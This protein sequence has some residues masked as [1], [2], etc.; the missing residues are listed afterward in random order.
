M[1]EK[2]VNTKLID[3]K[4]YSRDTNLYVRFRDNNTVH[5][6]LVGKSL[7]VESE[8]VNY[9]QCLLELMTRLPEEYQ[10]KFLNSFQITD[11]DTIE[12]IT[13]EESIMVSQY[14]PDEPQLRFKLVCEYKGKAFE[15][16]AVEDFSIALQVLQDKMDVSFNI[17]AFCSNADFR[18]TGGE[19]LRQG[20][21]CLRDVLNRHPDLPWFQREDEFQEA[22]SNVNAFHWCPS[23]VKAVD[24]ML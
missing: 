7:R 1:N 4:G 21:Y 12:I 8:G 19:D 3:E 9:A 23:Y 14:D 11:T 18:S 16:E 6:I 22:Y 24:R 10:L 13:V 5:V 15:A 2:I 20:W 17:C